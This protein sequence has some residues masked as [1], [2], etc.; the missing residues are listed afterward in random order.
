[1]NYRLARVDHSGMQT[2][3]INAGL[4][5]RETHIA[6]CTSPLHAPRYDGP[7]EWFR[8]RIMFVLHNIYCQRREGAEDDLGIQT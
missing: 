5:H 3:L 7:G 8:I 2:Y 6:I 1:L 4:K